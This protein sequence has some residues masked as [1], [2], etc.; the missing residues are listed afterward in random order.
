MQVW[1]DAQSPA[2]GLRLFGMPLLERLLRALVEAGLEPSRVP[3]ATRDRASLPPIPEDLAR[4]LPLHFSDSGAH[5]SGPDRGDALWEAV[6]R[7]Q[8][9]TVLALEGDCVVDPRLLRELG[10]RSESLAVLGG[11]GR[12]RAAVLL[13]T[14]PLHTSDTGACEPLDLV[15]RADRALARGDV[16]ELDRQELD[17]Y[18]PKLRR[19]LVPYLFRVPDRASAAR[20]ERFLFDA[21]YKGSTDF[22]TRYVYPPLVWR[23][24]RPLARWRVHP[25]WVSLLNVVITLGAIPLFA[26]AHWIAGLTLAYSMS[27]LDSVDGKLARLSFRASKLGHVLDHGLDVVHPPMW[28]LAWAWGLGARDLSTPLLQAGLWMLAFYVLDR[29]VTQAFTWRVGRSIHG[30]TALDRRLRTVISRRNIN[31]PIFTL[32]L[33][34]GEAP[35]AFLAIVAWQLVTLLFH[36][37]R[38]VQ[39]SHTLLGQGDTASSAERAASQNRPGARR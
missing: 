27:V 12:E 28:Y 14:R 2:S 29:L 31:L 16:D 33:V 23:L 39:V 36:A 4:V 5:G 13:W 24:V 35:A 7:A 25:N 38:L 8:G 1:I 15:R 26:S 20:A 30:Y 6:R 21:N 9:E 3:I 10:R 18:L 22:F 17:A 32:G 19:T 37:V 34:I 11:Q